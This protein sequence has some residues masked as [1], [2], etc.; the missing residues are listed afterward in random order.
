MSKQDQKINLHKFWKV[1]RQQWQSDI[2]LKISEIET[3]DQIVVQELPNI[4]KSKTL[5]FT[6]SSNPEQGNTYDEFIYTSTGWEQ[7]GSTAYVPDHTIDTTS[8]A[9]KVVIKKDSRSFAVNAE[10]IVKP[11]APMITAGANFYNSKSIEMSTVS[12][13]T[14]RYAMTTDGT[15][16][17]APT[18]TTGTA[19]SA[20]FSIGSTG[21]YQTIYKIVAVAI[22]NGMVSDPT[23]VQTYVCTRRVAAPTITIGGNKYASS[24]TITLT[25]TAADS[26]KCRLDDS[27]EFATYDSSSKPVITTSGQKVYAYSVKTDWADSKVTESSAVTL[28][29]KK[30]YIGGAGASLSSLSEL[31]GVEED[32][33]NGE[34]TITLASAAYI[35]FVVPSESTITSI[36]SGPL[37]VPFALIPNSVSGYNCYRTDLEI[38]AGTH[39]YN[40][41]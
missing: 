14:I 21:N 25:Q 27:G 33:L 13:A 34:R 9:G 23:E 8:L 18:E 7:V 36:T 39:T 20:V 10:E 5:Y 24:R 28:N 31:T 30:C 41:A 40:I 17:T 32:N 1:I 19:Y 4:G 35:W 22:K 29:A 15:T 12:G 11:D 37:A 26:I 38:I 3:F 16:P 2:N 6:P